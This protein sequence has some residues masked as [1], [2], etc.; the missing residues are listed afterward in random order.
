MPK[1]TDPSPEKERDNTA[2]WVT[3]AEMVRRMGVGINSGRKALQQMRKH[4]KFPPRSIGGKTYWPSAVDFFDL[5][6]GRRPDVPGLPSDQSH[7]SLSCMGRARASLEAA[8]ERLVRDMARAAGHSDGRETDP[9]RRILRHTDPEP[10]RARWGYTDEDGNHRKIVAGIGAG[11]VRVTA[12]DGR[13]WIEDTKETD[14]ASWQ[15]KRKFVPRKPVT[16]K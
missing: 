5:W 2:L 4:P 15:R 14:P 12:P 3:D 11:K 1:M 9:R 13:K 7:V 6:N 8:K 10:D 16:D